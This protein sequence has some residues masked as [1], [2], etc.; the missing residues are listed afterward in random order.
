MG[1]V[2]KSC[3]RKNSF[4]RRRRSWHT[5]VC[6]NKFWKL[7]E[8][9]SISGPEM[10]DFIHLWVVEIVMYFLQRCFIDCN[11]GNWGNSILQKPALFLL[12]LLGIARICGVG[13]RWR[14]CL[15]WN[16]PNDSIQ[17]L[18]LNSFFQCAF[19]VLIQ[20]ATLCINPTQLHCRVQ[21]GTQE[22][23]FIPRKLPL[24]QL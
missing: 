23:N 17:Q 11:R 16:V 19:L 3:S 12:R 6:K 13:R 5:Q 20:K 7:S 4:Y 15:C 2:D 18:L 22:L 8:V 14:W 21:K 1:S 9:K 10:C 24:F